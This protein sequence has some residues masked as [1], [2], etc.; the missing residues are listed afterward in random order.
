MKLLVSFLV[1]AVVLGLVIQNYRLGLRIDRLEAQRV[2]TPDSP[3][4]VRYLEWKEEE[5]GRDAYDIK[6]TQRIKADL[7]AL[8]NA[9]L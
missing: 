5:R 8:S 4:P 7:E 2:A 6:D 1:G 3:Q 9:L